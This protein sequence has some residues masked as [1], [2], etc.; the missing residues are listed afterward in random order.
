MRPEYGITL[1]RNWQENQSIQYSL[2]KKK[3]NCFSDVVKS[4]GIQTIFYNTNTD[5]GK[6]RFETANLLLKDAS[7]YNIGSSIRRASCLG[8]KTSLVA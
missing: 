8:S 2:S 3:K 1:L 7:Y 5:R 6:I 4:S